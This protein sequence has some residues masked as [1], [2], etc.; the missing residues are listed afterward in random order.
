MQTSSTSIVQ[1]AS[2]LGS[3]QLAFL[4]LATLGLASCAADDRPRLPE[5][6]ASDQLANARQCQYQGRTAAAHGLFVEILRSQPDVL[7][8]WEGAVE[9]APDDDA[10]RAEL[11][12]ALEARIASVGTST[13]AAMPLLTL[14]L[15]L[16]T[17]LAAR[18]K[19]LY[20]LVNAHPSHNAW[21]R[22][23]LGTVVASRGNHRA[24]LRFF[25]EAA[26]DAPGLARAW[27]GLATTQMALGNELDA[28]PAYE[29]YLRER[30]RDPQALYNLAL[31]LVQRRQ[32]PR[33][34]L[35]YLERANQVLPDDVDI[36]TNLGSVLLLQ[37][38]PDIKHAERCFVR[39]RDL[40]PQDPDVHYNLGV[41][42]ADHLDQDAKAISSF[43]RY[44]EL[45]GSG[46]ERV[47]AWIAELKK[48]S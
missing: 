28:V 30:P 12:R 31:I 2:R 22:T 48:G 46:Q 34:A 29:R 1:A 27:S 43:E 36:L 24:A 23:A 3:A 41:I 11:D 42:Y 9:T 21:P 10:G 14:R 17:D 33:D 26:D 45:G 25:A 35:P 40:S 16:T 44:L 7:G 4:V 32:R 47:R 19:A 39:A 15:E 38:D 20:D 5:L 18:E 8:A 6:N 37:N 13:P